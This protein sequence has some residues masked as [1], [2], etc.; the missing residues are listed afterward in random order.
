MDLTLKH[1][2]L[3]LQFWF[4]IDNV[5]QQHHKILNPDKKLIIKSQRKGIKR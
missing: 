3:K 4:Q 1:Q 5:A 2:N